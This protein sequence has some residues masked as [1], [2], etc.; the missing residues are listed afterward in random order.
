M[1]YKC[2]QSGHMAVECGSLPSR[3]LKMFGFGVPGQG[4]YSIE[5]PNKGKPEQFSGLVSVIGGGGGGEATE[6]KLDAELK[7]L[8][9]E[10]WDFQVRKF[11]NSEFRVSFPDQSSLDTFSKISKIVLAIYGLKVKISKSSIDPIAS[12]V[13]QPAWIKIHGV[14]SFAREE[15]VI[16]EITS[17]VAEPI[18]VD[19]FSLLRDEPIR[20]RVNCRDP[21]KLRGVVEIFFNGVGYDIK[22]AA[23]GTQGRV[24]GRGDGPSGS[25][26]KPDDQ[27]GKRGEDK[28]NGKS[29]RKMDGNNKGNTFADKDMDF[30]QGESQDD[31]MEDLI[32]DGSPVD[33]G[34]AEDAIPLAAYPGGFQ[35]G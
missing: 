16:K 12:V 13:L 25:R 31:S 34:R 15:E 20:V 21:A 14:P 8:V 35:L 33:E 3:K 6:A 24:P 32:R 2:K 19:D 1:C 11:T 29:F 23:E 22:F 7:N 5:L 17:L 4:F 30:R 28:E 27:S 9:S 10:Q 26:D 18:K